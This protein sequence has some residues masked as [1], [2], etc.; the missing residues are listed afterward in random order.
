[1]EKRPLILIS[2]DDGY[3]APGLRFLI[4]VLRPLADLVVVAPKTGQS[5]MSTAITVKVPLDLQCVSEEPGLVVYRSNGT[6]VDCVKLA[7]NILLADRKP[8]LVVSGVNH[9]SNASVAIH[10]SGT[11]GAVLEACMSGIPAIGFSLTNHHPDADFEPSRPYIAALVERVLEHSLPHGHCLNV[12]IPDAPQLR[13]M[14][15]CR[16]A[17]GRWVEEFDARKHPR[18]G[19]YYWLMGTF[20]NDEPESTDTDMYVLGE[21]YVSVVPSCIDM[22]AYDLLETMKAWEL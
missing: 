3:R 2:N 8:D 7:L 15:V 20:R 4:D 14:R 10:Y 21:G 9:G 1:M 12:N 19:D 13:G 11:M 6:P 5:G 17:N 22:T 16:Q 18:G